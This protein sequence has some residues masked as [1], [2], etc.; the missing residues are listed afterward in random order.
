MF[1]VSASQGRSVARISDHTFIEATGTRAEPTDPVPVISEYYFRSKPDLAFATRSCASPGQVQRRGDNSE[2]CG[3]CDI[4][5]GIVEMRRVGHTEHLHPELKL[6]PLGDVEV[7]KDA[8]IHIEVTWSTDDV[9]ASSAK[10]YLC[11]WDGPE[12][13][14]VE[15]MTRQVCGSAIWLSWTRSNAT[16]DIQ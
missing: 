2:G 7:P 16:D 15:V 6:H 9:A 3:I 14:R 1:S 10:P 5:A 4:S 8:S 11:W 12:R 13:G